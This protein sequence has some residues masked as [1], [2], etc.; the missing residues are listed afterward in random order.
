MMVKT[1]LYII[2]NMDTPFDH[3]KIW[4]TANILK[5]L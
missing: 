4:V 5:E 3:N 1:D 2:L